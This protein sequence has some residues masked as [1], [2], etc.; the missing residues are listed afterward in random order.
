MD[1]Q[2]PS[3]IAVAAL[4]VAYVLWREFKPFFLNRAACGKSTP[5]KS[6]PDKS[7]PDKS[8]LLQIDPLDP[9]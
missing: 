8:E 1:W 4:A 2:T 7:T 5:G 3:A 9:S 6:T